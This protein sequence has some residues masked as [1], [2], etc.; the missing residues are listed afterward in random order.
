[1][2]CRNYRDM[3]VIS[4]PDYRQFLGESRLFHIGPYAIENQAVLAPLAGATDLPFRL[5]CRER[6]AALATSEM[7]TSDTRLWHSDKSSHR[8]ACAREPGPISMQIAGN[9]PDM[10]SHAA[11]ECVERGA[12]IID[13]NMGCPAKKVCKKLAGSALLKDEKLVA[14]ILSAVVKNVAV[15]VTLKMRTGWDRENRNGVR[16]AKIA[17]DNGVSAITIHGRTRACRFIGDVEYDTIAD[18]V[19]RTSVPVIANGDISSPQQAKQVLEYTK[20][21]AIMIGR[22]ALGN[23][24]IF[25]QI[26]SYLK[27]NSY[28]KVSSYLKG[29]LK[30]SNDQ[31][32][33]HHLKEEVVPV[34]PSHNDVY[35]TVVQHLELLYAFYGGVQ[36]V[37][38]SRKHI[39]WYCQHIGGAGDFARQFNTLET[40]Q[41]QLKAVRDLFEQLNP[42]EEIAA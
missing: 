28:V 18:I 34:K 30:G 40:T 29:S 6:G 41:S 22:A 9:D 32:G 39:N 37:K 31:S 26:N 33:K 17:E 21:D 13:I 25:E 7:I 23:P 8:L 15:P 2:D 20:A 24:W 19:S 3:L 42:Y 36:G 14:Q 11:V 5:I 1:M 4:L 16:I 10:M 27:V 35:Q 38:I 12:N